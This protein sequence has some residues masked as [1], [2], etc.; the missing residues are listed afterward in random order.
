MRRGRIHK[1]K[2]V[3]DL[4]IMKEII[5][6]EDFSKLDIRAGYVQEAEKVEGSEK[7]IRLSV[8]VGEGNHRQVVAGIG[9]SYDPEDMLKRQVIVLVNLEAREIFGYK[10]EG[11]ILAVSGEEG[12]VIIAPVADVPSGSIVS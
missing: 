7:L 1:L 2:A 9:K 10:S 4:S 6:Y 11:M 5:K 12:P 8:D 3:N